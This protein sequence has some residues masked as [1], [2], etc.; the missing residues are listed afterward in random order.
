[1][2]IPHL[3]IYALS[4]VLFSACQNNTTSNEQK[5]CYASYELTGP[6]GKLDTMNLIDCE[7]KKQGKWVLIKPV[8]FKNSIS[9]SDTKESIKK[10]LV[11]ITVEEGYYK[12]DKK[13]GYWKYYNLDDGSLKDSVL[14]KN[15]EEVKN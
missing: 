14:Y 8:I 11:Y 2:R 1:M 15:G 13:T 9:P 5:K 7:K 12:D 4:L 6:E 10:K 3:N